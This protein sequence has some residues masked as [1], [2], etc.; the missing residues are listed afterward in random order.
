MIEI[1]ELTK[2]FHGDGGPVPV[3]E[4]V[5][6]SI[7]QGEIF[8][9][10]GRSGAGKST[11]VRCINR[12][13]RPT[14]GQ[15]IVAG[16]EITSLEGRALREARHSIGMI[17]QHFNLLSSRTVLDNVALPLEQRRPQEGRA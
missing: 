5:S 15:V 12:L 4:R 3:L 11:L 7:R 16:Q 6:L 13:E 8:G 9:I 10:I 1:R 14:S 17:F 2:C